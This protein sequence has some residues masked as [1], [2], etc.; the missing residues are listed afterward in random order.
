MKIN[1][2]E[3]NIDDLFSQKYMHKKINKNIYLNDVQISILQ[4]YNIDVYSCST[5]EEL[6]YLIDEIL[7]ED[8]IEEL[9]NISK[10]I[11]EFNYYANTNK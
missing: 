4:N 7:E 8:Y 11:S 3:I 1:N 6:L 9:D 2:E 5:I 10:E